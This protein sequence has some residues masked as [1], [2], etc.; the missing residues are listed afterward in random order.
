MGKSSIARLGTLLLCLGLAAGLSVGTAH[1]GQKE[2]K[3]LKIAS[4]MP[5]SGGYGFYG[6]VLKPG[7]EIYAEILNDDGGVKIGKDTYKIE[8]VFIDDAADPK[9][10]SQAAAE[11]IQKGCVANVGCFSLAAPIEA[12]L[13][14]AKVLFLAIMQSGIDLNEHRYYIAGQ[15][16]LENAYAA[17]AC[18]EMWPDMKK[19]G[20]LVYDWQAGNAKTTFDYMT[21]PGSPLSKAGVE[22]FFE[23]VPMGNQDFLVPL[24]KFAEKGVDTIFTWFGPGDFALLPKQALVQ[25]FKFRYF[26]AGTATDLEEFISIGGLENVQGMAFNWPAPWAVRKSKIEPD[27]IN[28]AVRITYRF[29]EK[30]GKP[31]TYVGGFNWGINH[32]RILLD[33]YQQAGSIDPDKAMEKVRGGQVRDFTG[34]WTMGG[35]K[36]WGSPVVKPS[37][38]L[39]G[40]I[41]GKEVVYGAEYPM[42]EIP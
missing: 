27:L 28:T 2:M 10:G 24:T 7:M 36:R 16:I 29:A 23:T 20:F 33:F 25:G 30:Y 22:V 17:Y 13:T 15:D 5:F 35:Q 14:P 12:A 42:P 3:T 34:T 41:R 40:K 21:Q 32:T 18:L 31:M 11:A 19:A 6:Q 38:C 37:A 1:A 9:R 4:I 8:M 39:V 26:N